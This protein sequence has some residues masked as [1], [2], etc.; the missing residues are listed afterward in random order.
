M[1]SFHS[2]SI[3]T[4]N[5]L[6]NLDFAN[7]KIFSDS[8]GSNNLVQNYYYNPSTW[9]SMFPANANLT[10]GIDAPDGSKNAVRLTCKTTGNSLLRVTF[11]SFTPNG[12]DT[13]IVSFWVRLISG[14]T[15]TA[16]G[17]GS[18]LNDLTPSI[19]YKPLLI[20]N[21]W[22]RVVTSA[23]PTATART[24]LDLLSDNTNDYTLDFWGVKIENQT[25]N[26]SLPLYD[27]I[28]GKAFNLYHPTYY[29]FANNS[30]QFTR[31]SS[32]PKWGGVGLF[33]STTGNLTCPN[34]LY[35][36]HTWEIWFKIDDRT[37]GNYD[38]TEGTNVLSV[39]NGY[40]AGF[41]YNSSTMLYNI[42]S[43]GPTE[44]NCA[45]W[46]LG[47]SGSQINQGSWYQIACVNRGGTFTPY[48]NGVQTGTGYNR[49]LNYVS[50]VTQNNIY[51]GA[52][53]NVSANNGSYVYYG[54]NTISNMKMYN[55]ALSDLEISQNFNAL[56]GRYGL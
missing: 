26:D 20:Q 13:Y 37:P 17:L 39:F 14:S 36:D 54:K 27:S 21:K 3:V 55:R 18:D 23:V 50:G 2:P 52:A 24:F 31:T 10:T 34:F 5:L 49:T 47:T 32:A 22:V 9:S 15:S 44:Y 19:D 12:T 40:H 25:T 38:I 16:N 41:L 29:N 43:T 42:W 4:T 48:L 6:L 7:P 56:R 33:S 30:I 8:I 1:S 28:S 35:N 46:T 45:S 51:I 11:N 53:A